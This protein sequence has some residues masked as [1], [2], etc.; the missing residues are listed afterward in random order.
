MFNFRHVGVKGEDSA[1]HQGSVTTL[2]LLSDLTRPDVM[3]LAPASSRLKFSEFKLDQE[4]YPNIVIKILSHSQRFKTMFFF[5]LWVLKTVDWSHKKGL[6][7]LCD[8]SAGGLNIYF[9]LQD[10]KIEKH[11]IQRWRLLMLILLHYHKS[12]K[13]Y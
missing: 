12:K 8:W 13:K 6:C 1:T 2:V 5:S 3:Y 4:T 10:I 9:L 7:D 11:Y